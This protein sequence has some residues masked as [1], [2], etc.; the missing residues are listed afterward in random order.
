MRVPGTARIP[1]D[2]DRSLDPPS[3][4]RHGVTMQEN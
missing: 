3:T 2:A 4:E 1:T